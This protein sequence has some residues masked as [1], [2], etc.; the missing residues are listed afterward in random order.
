MSSDALLK[1]LIAGCTHQSLNLCDKSLEKNRTL[2]YSAAKD[3]IS[4]VSP[5]VSGDVLAIWLERGRGIEA[6]SAVD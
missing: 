1:C 2:L 5:Y 4:R 6:D 3:L